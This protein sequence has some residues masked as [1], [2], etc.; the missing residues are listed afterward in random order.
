MVSTDDGLEYNT[1]SSWLQD[2]GIGHKQSTSD[3]DKNALA[4]LDRAVQDVKERFVRIIA[5]TGKGEELL[6]LAKALKAHNNSIHSS[7]HA[8]PNEVRGN[9]T[10]IFLNLVD[11]AQKFEHNAEL[12]DKRKAALEA[13]RAFRKPLPGVTKDLSLIHI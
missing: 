13:T 9:E 3:S 12:L 11:N 4:V 6:K 7:V 8:A 1:L 5:R 10:V 2:Q